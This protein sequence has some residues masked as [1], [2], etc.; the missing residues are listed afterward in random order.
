VRKEAQMAKT[1][2]AK[3]AHNSNSKLGPSLAFFAPLELLS[4]LRKVHM[5]QKKC[6]AW[7]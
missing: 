3:L 4:T 6:Q 7:A 2:K 5:G 1:K